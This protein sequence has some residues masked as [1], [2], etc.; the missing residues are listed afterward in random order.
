MSTTIRSIHPSEVYGLLYSHIFRGMNAR[1]CFLKLFSVHSELPICHIKTNPLL[2]NEMKRPDGMKKHFSMVPNVTADWLMLFNFTECKDMI[3]FFNNHDWITFDS[4]E[5]KGNLHLFMHQ[6]FI[7]C[8]YWLFL[9]PCYYT[10]KF[11]TLRWY[12]KILCYSF[13][14]ISDILFGTVEFVLR[15]LI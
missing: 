7:F 3:L 8:S 6:C 5:F 10:L 13:V 4:F 1:C 9:C 2:T 11:Y 12:I 15:D 14:Y